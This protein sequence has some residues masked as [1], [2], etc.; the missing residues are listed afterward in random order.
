[1]R[2]A[3]RSDSTYDD[4]SDDALMALAAQ[5]NRAAYEVIVRRH[6]RRVRGY[7]ARLCGSAALGDDVAQECFV[8]LWRRRASYT[9]QGKFKSYL[10]RIATNR[11]SNA[12]RKRGRETALLE[13]AE[14]AVAESGSSEEP[15]VEQHRRRLQRLLD[16]LPEPQREAIALR[17]GAGLDYREIASL[18]GKT[19]PTVRSRVFLGLAKLRKWLRPE[20]A[21]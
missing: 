2:I 4:R 14:L 6:Q 15:R 18:L 20:E 11:C 5:G 3:P 16:R 17:Y 21:R 10:F 9:G 13:G 8:E 19:E 1:M 7:C 12:R